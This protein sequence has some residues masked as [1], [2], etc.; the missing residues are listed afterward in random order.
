M[1]GHSVVVCVV[2]CSLFVF[3][4]RVDSTKVGFPPVVS[5]FLV[6]P[7][8]LLNCEGCGSKQTLGMIYYCGGW[9]SFITSTTVS[10]AS[11]Y[12]T[13][14]YYAALVQGACDIVHYIY[15]LVVVSF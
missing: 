12:A 14:L 11:R 15:Y 8:H 6:H 1:E 4:E 10:N 13:V 7:P 9:F 3:S 5:C 2:F